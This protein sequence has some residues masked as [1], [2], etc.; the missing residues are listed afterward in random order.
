MLLIVTSKQLNTILSILI[1]L[2]TIKLNLILR[3]S[4]KLIMLESLV[5]LSSLELLKKIKSIRIVNVFK[6]F[7]HLN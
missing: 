6:N 4:F 3:C 1:A 2:I 7:Y 5:F